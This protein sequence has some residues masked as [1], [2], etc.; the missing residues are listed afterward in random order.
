MATKYTDR[1]YSGPILSP[2]AI[3][4][5]FKGNVIEMQKKKKINNT[6]KQNQKLS[7]KSITSKIYW[8]FKTIHANTK[9]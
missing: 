4:A 7:D 2:P 6:R 5:E 8:Q 1:D 3:R 9:M